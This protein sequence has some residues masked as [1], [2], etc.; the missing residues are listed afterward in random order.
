MRTT[1]EGVGA[2]PS[3]A[4]KGMDEE[5]HRRLLS[6]FPARKRR[7]REET[8]R[9]PKVVDGIAVEKKTKM[10]KEQETVL[11]DEPNLRR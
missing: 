2:S 8:T 9:T 3:L 7:R 10:K 1:N 4:N 5:Q 11:E 6:Y